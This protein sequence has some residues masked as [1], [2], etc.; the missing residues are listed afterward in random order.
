M[1]N[2]NFE[3][4]NSS[5]MNMPFRRDILLGDNQIGFMESTGTQYNEDGEDVIEENKVIIQE[6][7]KEL[8]KEE[9]KNFHEQLKEF[10]DDYEIVYQDGS[11][12]YT[13]DDIL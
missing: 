2:Y 9:L 6:V 4:D 3:I 11:N 10:L 5:Y 13:I 7:W 12:Y 1:K 8:E